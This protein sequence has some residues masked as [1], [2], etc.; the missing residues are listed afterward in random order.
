MNDNSFETQSE[1]ESE[2]STNSFDN[3][4]NENDSIENQINTISTDEMIKIF[5]DN[6]EK[7][8]EYNTNKF[9]IIKEEE[10]TTQQR[11]KKRGRKCT[12]EEEKE[13]SHDKYSNDN[14]QRK[15]QVHYLTFI[16]SF[17]NDILA[18]FGIGNKFFN[19]DYEFK[20]T[21]NKRKSAELKSSNIGEIISNKV[22]E[23]F[24]K[25]EKN[26]N[27]ILYKSFKANGF[28]EKIF[29]MNYLTFFRM[30]YLKNEKIVDLRKFGIEKEIT[31]SEKTE[32]YYDLLKKEDDEEYIKQ[33]NECIEKNYKM[34]AIA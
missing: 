7:E 32:T 14:K 2:N 28:L 21:V 5:K 22:S 4:R 13:K 12:S 15:I 18:S 19:L 29:D 17:I 9:I 31:L 30:F 27:S 26:N 3:S 10:D 11:N 1:S 33:L 25:K 20:K 16:I 23:K 34:G 6:S 24:K 8:I